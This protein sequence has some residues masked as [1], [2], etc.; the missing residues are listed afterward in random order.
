MRAGHVNIYASIGN[1]NLFFIMYTR[2]SPNQQKFEN[3]IFDIFE[4]VVHN[5]GKSDDDLI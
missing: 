4:E 3:Q 1:H 5:I 2:S